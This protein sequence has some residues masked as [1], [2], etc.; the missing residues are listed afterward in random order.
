[1]LDLGV[2]SDTKQQNWMPKHVAFA[3]IYNTNISELLNNS[4]FLT[5][6]EH[7]TGSIGV[8]VEGLYMCIF[9]NVYLF[10]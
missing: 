3:F 7:Y 8:L 1:M 6:I 2:I 10:W 4:S 5:Q 9:I